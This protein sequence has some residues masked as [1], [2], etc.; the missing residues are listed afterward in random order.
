MKW[1]YDYVGGEHEKVSSVKLLF[2]VQR[3]PT[4][5]FVN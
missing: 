3:V 2:I 1:Q 5:E 4:L